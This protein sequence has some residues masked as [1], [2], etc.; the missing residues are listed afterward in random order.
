MFIIGDNNY[1]FQH[2]IALIFTTFVALFLATE[3]IH[4]RPAPTDQERLVNVLDR[5]D[6]NGRTHALKILSKFDPSSL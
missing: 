1:F 5:M 3:A 2:P 4:H 6:V